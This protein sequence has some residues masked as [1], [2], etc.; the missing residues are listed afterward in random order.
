MR[1]IKQAIII[2]LVLLIAGNVGSYFYLGTSVRKVPPVISCPEEI[3]EISASDNESV[4][5]TGVTATDEQDGDLTAKVTIAGI[6]KLITNDTA[7]VTLIVFDSDDNMTSCTRRIR[8]TDYHRPT[9]T[10]TEPLVYSTTEEVAMLARLKATDVVDGD[11]S[12]NIRVS[13]LEPSNNPEIYHV[14]IQASNSMGDTAWVRLPVLLLESNPLRPEILLSKSLEYVEKDTKFTPSAYLKSV[15]APGVTPAMED[16]LID[17]QVDSGKV[18]T[19]Y[20]TYTYS[21]NGSTGTAILT[22]VVQ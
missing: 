11:I 20:V 7:K 10:V 4:L 9:F 17:N 15:K 12:K 14:S 1:T 19:Y 2:L 5:L 21:A 13:T 6:S 18:G 16:V 8:Y 22:V 3:L